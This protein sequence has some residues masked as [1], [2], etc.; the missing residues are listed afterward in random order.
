MK[1]IKKQLYEGYLQEFIKEVKTA[2]V[3]INNPDHHV[4]LFKRISDNGLRPLADVSFAS[5]RNAVKYNNMFQS[6]CVTLG[7]KVVE[8]IK[9]ETIAIDGEIPDTSTIEI[10][11]TLYFKLGSWLFYRMKKLGWIKRTPLYINERDGYK[12]GKRR[13]A[14]R[15]L[16]KPYIIETKDEVVIK[17]IFAGIDQSMFKYVKK[18]LLNKPRD[19][20]NYTDELTGKTLAR[21]VPEKYHEIY[22][23]SN[24][25]LFKKTLDAINKLQSVEYTV[26]TVVLDVAL[27]CFNSGD[28]VI[29][30]IGKYLSK[31]EIESIIGE[32][33]YYDLEMFD[34]S[35]II[36]RI[37]AHPTLKNLT[38]KEKAK[39]IQGV[40]SKTVATIQTLKIAKGTAYTPTFDH[41][42]ERQLREKA[43]THWQPWYCDYRFRAYI[44]IAALHTQGSKLAK[45]LI[46]LKDAEPIGKYDEE[47]K[48]RNY[49][50]PTGADNLYALLATR[51][52]E[53]KI[54]LAERAEYA[55]D[56]YDGEWGKIGYDYLS[57]ESKAIWQAKGIDDPFGFIKTLDHVNK[58]NELDD[59]NEYPCGDIFFL[60][61][62]NQGLQILSLSARDELGILYA[63]CADLLERLDSY[64][65]IADRIFTPEQLMI[66]EGDEE[67]Y[68]ARLKDYN[69]YSG[70]LEK[71]YDKLVKHDEKI[72][73]ALLKVAIAKENGRSTKRFDDAVERAKKA[74]KDF[75]DDK[76]R[77]KEED[78]SKA[79]RDTASYGNVFWRRIADDKSLQRQSVKRAILSHFYGAKESKP[80]SIMDDLKDNDEFIGINLP[81]CTWLANRLTSLCNELFKGAKMFMQLMQDFAWL[82]LHWGEDF[83]VSDPITGAHLVIQPTE[84]ITK[85]I[86]SAFR[87][88]HEGLVTRADGKKAKVRNYKSRVTVG[89]VTPNEAYNYMNEYKSK[90]DW[91]KANDLNAKEYRRY[92]YM[93]KDLEATAKQ[94]APASVTHFMDAIFMRM[95]ILRING[96][97]SVSPVHDSFGSSVARVGQLYHVLRNTLADMILDKQLPQKIIN[98]FRDE[99]DD[100]LVELGSIVESSDY[101]RA[102]D[103]YTKLR[104]AIKEEYGSEKVEAKAKEELYKVG[105]KQFTLKEQELILNGMEHDRLKKVGERMQSF[106][107]EVVRKKIPDAKIRQGI[108]RNP[109][110]FS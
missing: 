26:N 7:R 67:I 59:I 69:K 23:V 55:R 76:V 42:N 52:G 106:D 46:E 15:K 77:P 109:F 2:R 90:L 93:M 100:R 6:D 92:R 43:N 72:R 19:Y 1:T 81:V 21:R 91:S 47:F 53:D 75:I 17:A 62:S 36:K 27:A 57:D 8:A 33:S 9:A 10:A 73:A 70:E 11:N 78:W 89:L 37:K 31:A 98:Q 14:V 85:V 102:H 108:L 28:K 4:Y 71:L 5:L 95:V 65:V 22:D 51:V 50:N 84:P 45:A 105:S 74:K 12:V 30:P 38:P 41:L 110:D 44:D 54:T 49:L 83:V 20:D 56:M 34:N 101:N 35:D 60:D 3:G 68:K 39:K 94:K 13:A 80:Y 64:T 104:K 63:N 29:A 107:I 99:V 24:N 103:K 32:F 40:K 88:D 58:A 86:E 25:E 96:E 66:A 79:L 82:R 87:I 97:F 48:K 16:Y 18:P 61:A